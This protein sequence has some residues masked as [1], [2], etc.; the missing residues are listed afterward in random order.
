METTKSKHVK[1]KETKTLTEADKKSLNEFLN[2]FNCEHFLDIAYPNS[3]TVLGFG[4]TGIHCRSICKGSFKM[5][6]ESKGMFME[7]E[8][9]IDSQ[10]SAQRY[11]FNLVGIRKGKAKF[12][13]EN[14]F[15]EDKTEE[16]MD[17][18]I[19]SFLHNS[20]SIEVPCPTFEMASYYRGFFWKYI[21][22]QGSVSEKSEQ[23]EKIEHQKTDEKI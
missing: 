16:E 9:D 8:L 18:F 4:N 6:D 21:N 20:G 2:V 3:R 17:L 7:N 22:S 13:V 23:F 19:L 5:W 14:E 10:M 11:S 12:Q 15:T 1:I